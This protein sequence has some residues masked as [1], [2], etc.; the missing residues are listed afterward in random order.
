M[1]NEGDF[2]MTGKGRTRHLS[3]SLQLY[4]DDPD[5]QFMAAYERYERGM[6]T[7]EDLLLLDEILL[8]EWIRKG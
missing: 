4:A 5:V 6:A 2:V 7:D 1:C 3:E 8:M